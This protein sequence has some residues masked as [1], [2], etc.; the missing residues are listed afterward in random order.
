MTLSETKE[1]YISTDEKL[2]IAKG[3]KY[4]FRGYI[5]G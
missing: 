5:D 2:A 4:I 1:C 3:K